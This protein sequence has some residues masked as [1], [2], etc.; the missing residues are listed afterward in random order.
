MIIVSHVPRYHLRVSPSSPAHDGDS[1]Y[2]PAKNANHGAIFLK[3][4]AEHIL[5]AAQWSTIKVHTSAIF[6][7]A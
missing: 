5:Q 7:E 6:P 4:S 3:G 1:A 2:S